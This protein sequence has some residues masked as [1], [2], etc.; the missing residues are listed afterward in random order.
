VTRFGTWWPAFSSLSGS[1]RARRPAGTTAGRPGFPA[2]GRPASPGGDRSASGAARGMGPSPLGAIA[3]VAPAF[4]RPVP[5]LQPAL[6][7]AEPEEPR[8]HPRARAF[9]ISVQTRLQCKS[10]EKRK[11]RQGPPGGRRLQQTCKHTAPHAHEKGRRGSQVG[12]DPARSC[13]HPR[14][15]GSHGRPPADDPVP[16]ED[17]SGCRGGMPRGRRRPL[18]RQIPRQGAR[19]MRGIDQH[20]VGTAAVPCSVRF[21]ARRTGGFRDCGRDESRVGPYAGWSWTVCLRRLG[22]GSP[23]YLGI[24]RRPRFHATALRF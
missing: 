24:Q 18:R 23:L 6:L 7:T 10:K 11:D 22:Q 12:R 19:D 8:P 5:G 14:R 3:M 16:M 20:R 1:D 2:P 4:E 15:S 13:S 21:E 9:R 17:S